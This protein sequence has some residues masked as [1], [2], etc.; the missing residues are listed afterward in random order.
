MILIVCYITLLYF[1]FYMLLC[2]N[3]ALKQKTVRQY[4]SAFWRRLISSVDANVSNEP[5]ASILTAVRTSNLTKGSSLIHCLLCAGFLGNE[6][7]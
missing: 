2:G 3:N 5:T 1:N 7:Y 4:C 6:G